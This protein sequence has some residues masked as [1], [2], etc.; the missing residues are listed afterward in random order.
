MN[1]LE[2]AWIWIYFLSCKCWYFIEETD[3]RIWWLT[4][5]NGLTV[6]SKPCVTFM[7]H[8]PSVC[9]AEFPK[10]SLVQIPL[11]PFLGEHTGN[12]AFFHIVKAVL[13]LFNWRDQ[14]FTQGNICHIQSSSG[15]WGET[16][17][18]IHIA[19]LRWKKQTNMF[20]ASIFTVHCCFYGTLK[21]C[22]LI[23]TVNRIL[24]C[25]QR[26]LVLNLHHIVLV[27]NFLGYIWQPI[28]HLRKYNL[29]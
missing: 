19:T 23:L 18:D 26:Y 24:Q 9:Q 5:E 21:H 4:E 8:L 7:K 22:C 20:G 6:L 17:V 16:S 12:K 10:H 28:G 29:T 13:F 11:I 1:W 2:I 25:T 15:P 27:L 14:V 3:C